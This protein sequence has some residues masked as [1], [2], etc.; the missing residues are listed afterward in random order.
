[1][2][3]ERASRRKRAG[4]EVRGRPGDDDAAGHV[5]VVDGDRFARAAAYDEDPAARD[6]RPPPWPAARRHAPLHRPAERQRRLAARDDAAGGRDARAAA[7]W[8]VPVAIT[9]PVDAA[10]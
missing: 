9:P 3:Q 7:G 1:M 8:A 2:P 6:G 4:V 10:S 5:R